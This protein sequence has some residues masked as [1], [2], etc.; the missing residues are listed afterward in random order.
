RD[1]IFEHRTY[2]PS[3]GFS[4]VAAWVL[5]VELPRVPGM[6]RL[7]RPLT[8]A[9]L[10]AMG[11]MT[12]RRNQ[13][14]R[15]PVTLWKSNVALAPTKARV[16]GNYGR[17]LLE[18]DRPEEGGR[19]LQEAIRIRRQEHDRDAG[20]DVANMMWALRVLKRYDEAL[21]LNAE[22]T[23][24]PLPD[25]VRARFY[26]NEGSVYVDQGQPE[27]AE[28]AYRHALALAPENLA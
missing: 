12:W 21:A 9:I 28:A 18:A 20:P 11:V 1:V 27:K 25:D 3:L 5:L 26:I 14:W 17:A 22:F 24:Q 19:A 2:L 4:L 23:R 16:W 8:F 13:E 15:D 10:I 6:A 7:A